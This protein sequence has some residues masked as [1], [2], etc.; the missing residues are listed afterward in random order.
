MASVKINS[1]GVWRTIATGDLRV[2][3]GGVWVYPASMKVQ[4]GG[5]WRD[6]GYV[7]YPAEP[8][9]LAV[10][11]WTTHEA[12]SFTWK[13][14]VGGAPT[15]SYDI[16]INNQANNA[17]VASSND[18]AAPSI[19]FTQVAQYTKY[20]VYVRAKSAGG[21]VSDWVGPLKIWM[22]K[23][24]VTTV[25]P[26]TKTRAW[27]ESQAIGTNGFRDN[28]CGVRA[29]SSVRMT[30]IRY[31]VSA[32]GG[33]TSILSPYNNREIFYW[34]DNVQGGRVSWS[35]P[36]DTGNITLNNVSAGTA[37]P[38]GF[39]CRGI[40]WSSSASGPYRVNGTIY[41]YGTET[42]VENVSSTV[43]AINNTYW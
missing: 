30:A 2:K 1:G 21:L 8:T 4:S 26:T 38:Q 39:I 5:A 40:G 11:S 18:A 33:F 27:S 17:V 25:T 32:N 34:F 3:A 29:P 43:P 6:T 13:A 14:G 16:Q 28:P 9:N 31:I 22:G 12:V 23:D 7:G 19:S 24:A 35:S 20:N 37:Y 15:A 41:L 42:Y 36:E 10:Y